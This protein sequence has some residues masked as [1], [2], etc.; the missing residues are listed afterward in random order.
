MA[1]PH[2]WL[3]AGPNGAGKTTF[4]K[5][6]QWSGHIRHFLNADE[7]TRQMLKQHGFGDYAS[8]PPDILNRANT[9]AADK[10]FSEVCRLLEQ[11]EAVAAETVLSTGKYRPV[12]NELRRNNGIFNLIYIGLRSPEI[13]RERVVRRVA[14][15]GHPVSEEKLP[16][17]WRRSLE[18][19]PWFARQADYFFIYDNSDSD[20]DHK[21]VLIGTKGRTADSLK[22]LER[23]INPAMTKTLLESNLFTVEF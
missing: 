16:K 11:G 1:I 21:P 5:M 15:G 9:V 3:F 18:N 23:E 8:T 13:S 22:L 2:L 14:L 6:P 4:T 7:L 19:L 10:V 12:V 20:P 17:R